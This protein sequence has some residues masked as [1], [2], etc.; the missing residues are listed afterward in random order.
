M[1]NK[2]FQIKIESILGGM[3]PTG[4]FSS[5]GQFRTSVAINPALPES[6]FQTVNRPAT[7]LL[8]PS[9]TTS[10][11]D[12]V[13][14]S[15]VDGS[16][17]PTWIKTSTK[18]IL[19]YVYDSKGSV[20]TYN[21]DTATFATLGDLNDGGNSSG[22]GCEYYDNYMYFARDTTIARY[23][24]LNGTPTFT[25]DYWVGV[26]GKT[27][28]SDTEYPKTRL[29]TTV[30]YPNHILHRHSD[31]RLYIID[32]VDNRGTIHYISTTKTTVEGDTDNGSTYDALD[33]GYGLWPTA[34]ES[35]GNYL[36][37]ALYEGTTTDDSTRQTVAK[38]AFWDTT[39]TNAN[40]IT[41][42]EYPD[43]LV[44]A[45]K[46]VNGVLYLTSSNGYSSGFRVVRYIGGS[47]FEEV[48]MFEHGTT[49]FAGAVD[50][51]GERLVFGTATTYPVSV[52]AVYSY[53]LRRSGLGQ[54]L[55]CIGRT[56]TI[57]AQTITALKLNQGSLVF[58]N[59]TIGWRGNTSTNQGSGVGLVGTGVYSSSWPS[60]W[61]SAFFRIG[62]PFKITKIRI[63][64]LSPLSTL[65]DRSV[66]PKLY[67]D[68]ESTTYTLNTLNPTN[69]PN[70]KTVTIRPEN[71]TGENGFFLELKWTGSVLCVVSLPITIEYELIDD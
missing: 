35:Y 64:L 3:S 31:G 11:D 63:P 48:A 17:F 27:V 21:P 39:S 5:E 34:I 22:N 71:A 33:F 20:Y 23:G 18:D 56:P 44:S 15:E 4:Y 46:N 53:G 28:L 58:D 40:Q 42:V 26:L 49:P 29:A 61:H 47:S 24:P 43:Q 12:G 19:T 65:T 50:G 37:I 70:K 66:I 57:G 6:D 32:V 10:I 52:G 36:V 60:I 13:F 51:S 68:D 1:A 45:I 41:W 8:R 59:M 25:D 55:H 62:Q 2:T 30:D 67:M 69:Y 7:G 9:G 54:G 14:P 38:I 16:R